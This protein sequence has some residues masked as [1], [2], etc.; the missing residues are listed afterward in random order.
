M[1]K[2]IPL[3]EAVGLP[4]AH[5]ITEIR[6][7]QFKG[8]AFSRGHIV[9]EE[10]LEHL[11]RLGKTHIF[12]LQLEANQLHED[13]AARLL[14]EALCGP[15]ARPAGLPREGRVNIV[16]AIDGLFRVN[17]T[18]LFEFN[19]LGEVMCSCRHGDIVV[20]RGQVL[21]GTRAIPL[22]PS[23]ELVDQAIAIAQRAGGVFSVLELF[24]RK[25]GLVV[26]GNEV[27][28]GLIQDGFVPA[29]KPKIARLGGEIIEVSFCPD[30]AERIASALW[31]LKE[32][33]AELIIAAGGMSVD[34]DDVTRM[35]IEK[36][37]AHDIAY[38][39]AVLPGAMGLV[40]YLDDVPVLG[41]PGCVIYA[42]ST[43]LD[44]LLPRL[45][46]GLKIDR[47]EIA[48]LGHGGMCLGCSDCRFPDCAFG[49]G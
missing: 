36:A 9:Q 31:A 19:L 2:K 1:I 34:P 43:V 3:E 12:V 14:A 29:V 6:P 45:M 44:I 48:R 8:V 38:G 18:A 46:A 17:T 35:G 30:D 15:G 21:A 26:T 39:T 24:R 5:D 25:I 37:G 10:D 7:G 32:K 27:F 4:L 42:P 28:S 11:R 49:K 16:A 22:A 41:A 47:K 20:R 13:D 40:A 33:G 23:K